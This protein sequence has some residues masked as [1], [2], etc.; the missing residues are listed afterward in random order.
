[1]SFRP[2]EK[3]IPSGKSAK[4]V[5]LE[6]HGE[7]LRLSNVVLFGQDGNLRY[8]WIENH[9]EGLTTAAVEGLGDDDVM[10]VATALQILPAKQEV[11]QSGTPRTIE[12][13]WQI[14]EGA[15]WF[16]LRIEVAR[17]PQ[18]RIIGL[19]CAAIDVSERKQSE[20]HLRIL[21]LELAHRSKNLLAVIQ[22][23]SNQTAQSS[24]SIEEFSRRFSGRLMS[25]SRAHD[26][27]S[28]QNWRGAGMRELIRTQV[29]LFA[30]KAADNIDYNGDA[31]YLRPNAAQH[32]GLAL[33]ELTANALKYGA[34][35]NDAG[36]VKIRWVFSTTRESTPARFT[37]NWQEKHGPPVIAP[38][39]RHFG[40]ILL[41]EVVPLSVQGTA[42]LEFGAGGVHYKL[43]MPASELS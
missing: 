36:R 42:A 41:E 10:P 37:L 43:T 23:I 8:Q 21:L 16:E 17:D 9:P 32:V 33:Y 20:S 2:S 12:F 19:N 29:L 13:Q 1:V 11:L 28:D 3:D 25:L 15:R 4:E 26:I 30:G 5:W 18:G 27:L 14:G 39:G 24:A 35:S 38:R 34:L 31:V 40:R 7:A 6:R 22:G